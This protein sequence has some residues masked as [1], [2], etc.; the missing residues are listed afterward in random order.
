MKCNAIQKSILVIL[1]LS[2]VIFTYGDE[3]DYKKARKYLY[4]GNS[5]TS[6]GTTNNSAQIS[7]S[8]GITSFLKYNE[9]GY[10]DA[11]KYF[12][13]AIKLDQN[14]AQA[15]ARLAITYEYHGT[16]LGQTGTNHDK[17]YDNICPNAKKAVELSPELSIA[18]RTM[19]ICLNISKKQ[20]KKIMN[21]INTAIKLDPNAGENYFTRANLNIIQDIVNALKDYE[22]ASKLSPMNYVIYY[23][24]GTILIIQKKYKEAIKKLKKAIEIN[25]NHA[26]VYYNMACI[27][28]LKRNKKK[29]IEYLKKALKKGFNNFIWMSK[30]TDLDYVRNTSEY[31]KLIKK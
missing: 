7:Y 26:I 21:E 2:I 28:S 19:A 12:K 17:V 20:N 9:S 15:Y 4:N 3:S 18:H 10:K 5:T 14:Y 23:N 1:F 8:L 22:T 25:P 27:Y 31:K 29:A 24:W 13:Q 16:H 30:D 11:I 6:A